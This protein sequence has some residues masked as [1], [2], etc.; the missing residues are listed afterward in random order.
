MSPVVPRRAPGYVPQ[1]PTQGANPGNAFM[2]PQPV[3]IGPASKEIASLVQEHQRRADEVSLID[4]DSQLASATDQLLYDPQS[5]ALTKRGAD[6][7]HAQD[8]A[9]EGWRKTVSDITLTL[10]DRQRAQFKGIVARRSEDFNRTLARHVAGEVDQWEKDVTD[11]HLDSEFSLLVHNY[12]DPAAVQQ[13]IDRQRAVISLDAERTGESP[14]VTA[15][16]MAAAT[17]RSHAAVIQLTLADGN[18]LTAAKYFQAH[19]GQLEPGQLLE[20]KKQVDVGS[21]RGESQRRSDSILASTA[22]LGG[23]MREA[24]KIEDPQLRDATQERIGRQ[25][26]LKN[27]D[28]RFQRDDAFQRAG[29]VLRQTGDLNTISPADWLK[30][31]PEQQ[32]QLHHL[33]SDQRRP[34]QAGDSDLF[35]SLMN[36]SSLSGTRDQFIHTDLTSLKAKLSDKQYSQVLRRQLTL[37]D[38]S[39]RAAK[40]GAPS[41]RAQALVDSLMGRPRATPAVPGAPLRAPTASS[42]DI[43]LGSGPLQVSAADLERARRDAGYRAYLKAHGVR[44][45]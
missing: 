7:I 18:D 12:N 40:K 34:N 10:P 6:A 42:G 43:N 17:S 26:E 45:P 39:D 22:T 37:R 33:D 16:R 8:G 20:I 24:A 21:L 4:A 35:M 1:T 5:G 30:L 29:Q 2:P 19:A 3:D 14:D 23:A 9:E 38:E 25:Y 28:E 15:Q 27:A 31:S 44:V 36:M 41:A 32:I 13:G 11:A